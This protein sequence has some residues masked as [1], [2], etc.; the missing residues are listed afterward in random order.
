MLK[1][2]RGVQFP[3]E[4]LEIQGSCHPFS[5]YNLRNHHLSLQHVSL[6]AGAV[7]LGAVG[8]ADGQAVGLPLLLGLAGSSTTPALHWHPSVQI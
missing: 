5:G 3:E 1:D 2:S 6:Q 7:L 8:P 4:Q